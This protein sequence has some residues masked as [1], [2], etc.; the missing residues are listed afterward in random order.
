MNLHCF[1][2]LK[3]TAKQVV[4]Q[5]VLFLK[6]ICWLRDTLKKMLLAFSVTWHI[7]LWVFLNITL[8]LISNS[9]PGPLWQTS[10]CC[11]MGRWLII[12]IQE[13]NT[14]PLVL[15]HSKTKISKNST[16]K[17]A[18]YITQAGYAAQELDVQHPQYHQRAEPNSIIIPSSRVGTRR[19]GQ[20]QSSNCQPV[21]INTEKGRERKNKTK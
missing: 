11:V 8:F 16:K 19:A 1:I 20:R 15:T 5:D 18:K 6:R 4:F 12:Q 9:E 17:K 14:I 13:Q 3:N 21:R 2:I 10:V 7:I